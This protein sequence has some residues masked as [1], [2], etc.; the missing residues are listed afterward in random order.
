MVDV[1]LVELALQVVDDV[2]AGG[3]VRRD[4]YVGPVLGPAR[5]ALVVVRRRRCP[6]LLLLRV[7]RGPRHRLPGLGVGCGGFGPEDWHA[8]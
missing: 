1:A 4:E 5:V 2:G 6:L 7:G 8:H 3:E